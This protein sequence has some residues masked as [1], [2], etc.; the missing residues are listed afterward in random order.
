MACVKEKRKKNVCVLRKQEG[1]SKMEIEK[2]ERKQGLVLVDKIVGILKV[3][4]EIY[5]NGGYIRAG[6][7]DE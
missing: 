6:F 4:A 1:F 3:E 5:S 2:V 7:P